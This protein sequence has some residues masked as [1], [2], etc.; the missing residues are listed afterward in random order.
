MSGRTSGGSSG[1][2]STAAY[3][4]G[5]DVGATVGPS[6]VAETTLF[7]G[8]KPIIAANL[9]KVNDQISVFAAGRTLVNAGAGAANIDFRV[10]FGAVEILDWSCT[11]IAVNALSRRWVLEAKIIVRTIGAAGTFWGGGV[12]NLS[13]AD[14]S[15]DGNVSNDGSISALVALPAVNTTAAITLDV[16]AQMSISDPAFDVLCAGIAVLRAPLG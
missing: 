4:L 7:A 6:S 10:R 2:A 11:T 8:A 14:A 15:Q 5:A 3:L 12:A 16:T 9:L 13:G 1:G